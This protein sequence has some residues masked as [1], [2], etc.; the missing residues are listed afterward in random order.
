MRVERHHDRR[1]AHLAGRRL[2][3]LHNSG[4]A[5]MHTELL[6]ETVLRDFHELWPDKI[7][8]KTNGV[9]PRRFVLFANPRQSALMTEVLGSDAWVRDLTL[10]R[11]LEKH[12]AD[13]SF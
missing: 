1:S 3:P 12:A 8:N 13:S 4:V 7:T 9:T 10:L 5:A 6:K 11:G 2:Q